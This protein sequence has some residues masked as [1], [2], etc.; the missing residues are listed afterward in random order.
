[1]VTGMMPSWLVWAI[2]AV[3]AIWSVSVGA[4]YVLVGVALMAV[5][6]LLWRRHL[7]R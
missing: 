1:M 3:A 2:L 4:W 5:I 7:G 6:H